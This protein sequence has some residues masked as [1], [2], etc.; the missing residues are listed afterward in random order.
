LAGI[1]LEV[2]LDVDDEGRA[3]RGEQTGLG[4]RSTLRGDEGD[5]ETHENQGGVKVPVVLC[6]VIGIVLSCLS[7]V[8]GIEI[9]LRVVV[10]DWLEVYAQGL[11]NAWNT[12]DQLSS[13]N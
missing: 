11:L 2:G 13:L 7:L 12:Q 9:E 8:H 6:H 4:V 5:A 1:R 10:L 3:D